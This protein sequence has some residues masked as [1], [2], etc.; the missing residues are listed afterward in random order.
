MEDYYI[1]GRSAPTILITGTLFAS[2]LSTNGFMGDTAYSYSGNIT[3]MILL[4]TLCASGYVIGA[5]FFGR[6]IRR[7]NATTMPEYFGN[8]FNSKRVRR[9]AGISVIISLQ[10]YLLAVI[11]GTGILMESL[12]GYNINTCLFIAWLCITSFTFYAGSKGVIITDTIMFI[13]FLLAVIVGGPFIFEKAGGINNLIANLLNNPNTPEGLLS[14]HGNTHGQSVF[15]IV[16]YGVTVGI[17]WLI[18]VAVSP[19]QAGRNLMAKNEHVIFR[20]SVLT[21]ICTI[22][23]LTYLYLMAVSVIVLNPNMQDPEKVLIWAALNVMPNFIGLM[24][25]A[26]IMAAGL[27]SASTFLSVISFSISS[28]IFNIKFSSEKQH[29]WFT[30]AVVLVVSI[31]ALYLSTLNLSSI[32]IISWF[33]STIIASSWGFIA[34]ASVWSKKI[35]ERGAYLSMIGGFFGYIAAKVLKE[36][37]GM[38]FVNVFDPFFIGITISILLGIIGSINQTKTQEEEDFQNSIHKIPAKECIANDYKQDRLYGILLITVGIIVS[39]IFI[40]FWA[41]P[42]NS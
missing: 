19:W 21:A 41:V 25:L 8:R 13:I 38:P 27:S 39:F 31:T 30:R 12:T 15:D 10:A 9:F 37:F 23:F 4:N 3:T 7:A 28:D 22:V 29:I 33:A 24:V 11:Q 36:I 35:T 40:K 17:I 2:M 42:V 18:T 6:Y 1:S 16:F 26:G 34:F 5:L 14:Y 32:R 20:S